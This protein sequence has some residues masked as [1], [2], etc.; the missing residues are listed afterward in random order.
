[1]TLLE[2]SALSKRFGGLH[3][4]D[5]MSFTVD[6][7]EILGLIGPN[8]S[9]KSTSLLLTMGIIRPD[10]GSV[11]LDG[12]PMAGH[13]T[14]AIARAGM[15]MVFQ[16]SRPLRRQTVLENIQ[17]ALLSDS[18]WQWR[19]N[20]SIKARAAAVAQRVGLEHALH[21][22]PG[23]LPFAD[24]RRLEVAKALASNPRVLLLDEPFAGLAPRETSEFSELFLANSMPSS[25]I[26]KAFLSVLSG[27]SEAMKRGSP[28]RKFR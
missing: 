17:L 23:A 3:A 8:G 15:T 9:G 14:H 12:H 24:L 21:L 19:S 28:N 25:S 4:V 10:Q 22:R 13:P 2:V 5:Q 1:M 7:G 26:L 11:T 20:P 27:S 6:S 16:H 18:L